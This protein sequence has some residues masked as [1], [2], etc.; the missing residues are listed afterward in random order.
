MIE[1][2]FYTPTMYKPTYD[3]TKSSHNGNFLAG[4]AMNSR[5]SILE[6]QVPTCNPPNLLGRHP[7]NVVSEDWI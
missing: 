1:C 5:K 7:P 3:Y 2:L 4:Y 6:H